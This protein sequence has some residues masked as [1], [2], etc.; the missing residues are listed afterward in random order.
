MQLLT[1]AR[2]LMLAGDTAQLYQQLQETW[3]YASQCLQCFEPAAMRALIQLQ[4]S[5]AGL[6]LHIRHAEEQLHTARLSDSAQQGKVRG[7]F[8]ATGHA[9]VSLMLV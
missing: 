2:A 5:Q 8:E 3:H 1:R 9:L 7:Q 6:S 4:Q